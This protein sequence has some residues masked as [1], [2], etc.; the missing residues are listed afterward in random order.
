M[1]SEIFPTE[2]ASQLELLPGA[3]SKWT[4]HLKTSAKAYHLIQ[5][6]AKRDERR[7]YYVVSKIVEAF[8]DE[9][10]KIKVV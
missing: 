8:C 7:V 3:R 9:H 10:S 2:N 1:S 5:E 4:V 6:I